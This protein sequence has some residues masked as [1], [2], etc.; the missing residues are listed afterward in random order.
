[1]YTDAAHCE[2]CLHA[3]RD[4]PRRLLSNRHTQYF[5]VYS[6]TRRY[7]I[8]CSTAARTCMRLVRSSSFKSSLQFLCCTQLR[9]SIPMDKH[10]LDE[11]N[12]PPGLSL[13]LRNSLD[14]LL[15]PYP[16]TTS[17]SHQQQS[18][19]AR[20]LLAVKRSLDRYDEDSSCSNSSTDCKKL[21]RAS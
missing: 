18:P 3:S 19:I 14:W 7:P 12:L 10:V 17:Q 1:M 11:V 13:T 2:Y 4:T 9:K 5:L 16:C 8:I 20:E 6:H 21:K 15:R